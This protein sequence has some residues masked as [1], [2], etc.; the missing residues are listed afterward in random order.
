MIVQSTS[1][2]GFPGQGIDAAAVAAVLV[3]NHHD[4]LVNALSNETG[5]DDWSEI[6]MRRTAVSQPAVF[7]AGV[8]RAR[9]LDA[10][11]ALMLGH[12][13]GE[14]TS[15]AAAGAIDPQDGLELVA[16]RA[17]ACESV[18][19]RGEMVAVM[20]LGSVDMEWV[21]RCAIGATGGVVEVA[22]VNGS[23][24]VV[25]SGT[26]EAIEACLVEIGRVGGIAQRLSIGGG[27]HSPLMADAVSD[28]REALRT[29]NMRA[30]R[31]PW[32][33][34]VDAALHDDP[35]E[36]RELLLRAL[37]LPVKW[38]ESLAQAETLGCTTFVDIGP[39]RTLAKLTRRSGG[40]MSVLGFDEA[41][42]GPR[43]RN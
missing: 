1:A 42:K 11:P 21:R 40:T 20:G 30:P 28:F 16:A 8:L 25:L 32:L 5:V 41:L 27:F 7:V 35:E 23:S 38:S 2:W 37:L 13:L 19:R 17:R 4:A 9:R 15:L 24:Q 36:V 12:S 34:T 3:A 26:S 14:L 39:D 22:A 43:E 33:S 29:V 18:S 10:P 6:D 31:V